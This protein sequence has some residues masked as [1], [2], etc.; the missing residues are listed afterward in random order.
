MIIGKL[1][2]KQVENTTKPGLYGDGGN[3]YFRVTKTGTKSWL[4]IYKMN[5]KQRE[6]GLGSC[7]AVSLAKARELAANARNDIT[8][9]IDPLDL[10]NAANKVVETIKIPTFGELAEQVIKGLAPQWKNPKHVDQ[11]R[12][13]LRD[14]AKPICDK[15]VCDINTDLVLS[16][17][18]PIW[19]EKT[20]TATRVRGR[21]EKVLYAANALGY[22]S[23]ENPAR[24]RGHLENLLPKPKKLTRGHHSA[25]PYTD[26]PAFMAS[27]RE[28]SSMSALALEM[29][30]L[31]ASRSGEI[32][33][34][35]WDEVNLETGVWIIPAQRMKAGVI[36]R[37]PLSARALE[38][39][40]K[41]KAMSVKGDQGPTGYVFRGARGGGLSVMSLTMQMRRMN[42][43]HYTP[44]GFRSSFRDWCGE[45]TDFSRELAE[46][47][48]AHKV[49][50][51]T[52]RAYRR[53][54][55]LDKRREL[56]A[57]WSKFLV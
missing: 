49:G 20:E 33:G 48:L 25:M 29:L 54:D 53:G 32:L 43:G 8:N 16:A 10:R 28:K 47:S 37:V 45:T 51:A 21:I 22:R 42:V 19:N 17:L 23:G 55:M 3:L 18:R 15:P 35:K 12:N 31:C 1:K 5:G 27:L 7:N 34:M 2:W 52:E 50:D 36:H 30:I 46:V 44:H 14:Y 38:I 57:A 39:L 9:G 40:E 6:M 26:L 11:W 41:V 13:T 4:F 24:W 56:I